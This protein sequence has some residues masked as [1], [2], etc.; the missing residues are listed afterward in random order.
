MSSDLVIKK[1]SGVTATIKYNADNRPEGIIH[2]EDVSG[3]IKYAKA[4]RDNPDTDR[5]RR[6]TQDH[7]KQI[8]HIPNTAYIEL[9][10]MFGPLEENKQAWI[11]HIYSE[12]PYLLTT[13]QK[14]YTKG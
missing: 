7:F 11:N 1:A 8:A 10:Q 5:R 3:A 13:N 12:M 14:I 2:S 9:H 6:N 4:L